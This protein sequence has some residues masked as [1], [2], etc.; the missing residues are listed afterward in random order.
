[1]CV[2]PS[3]SI[4]YSISLPLCLCSV[5]EQYKVV[6]LKGKRVGL[7]VHVDGLRK[8]RTQYLVQWEKGPNGEVYEDSWEPPGNLEK[9][10]V[11]DFEKTLE[12]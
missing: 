9:S 1:M 8:N 6:C 11:T 10:L 4:L 3:H 12:S 2:V 5:D 7:G